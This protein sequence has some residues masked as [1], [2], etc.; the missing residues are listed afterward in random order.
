[1]SA[2]VIA[3]THPGPATAGEFGL[4]PSPAS[5]FPALR[6]CFYAT[7]VAEALRRGCLGT[8]A[9]RRLHGEEGQDVLWVAGRPEAGG[10]EAGR[11]FGLWR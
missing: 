2:E 9:L 8:F 5:W 6:G 4:P 10:S 3:A 1:M 7:R 11:G